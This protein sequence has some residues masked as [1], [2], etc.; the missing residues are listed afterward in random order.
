M[1]HKMLT[2][3]E[4]HPAAIVVNSDAEQGDLALSAGHLVYRGDLRRTSIFNGDDLAPLGAGGTQ[5]SFDGGWGNAVLNNG[6]VAKR[7]VASCAYVSATRTVMI[8]GYQ[9][10]WL[11]VGAMVG[12]AWMGGYIEDYFAVGTV[13]SIDGSAVTFARDVVGSNKTVTVYIPDLASETFPDWTGGAL[14]AAVNSGLATANNAFAANA[15]QAG[16]SAGQGSF[17]AALNLGR[18]SGLRAFAANQGDATAE[19]ATALGTSTAAGTTSL[20]TG[21]ACKTEQPGTFTHGYG[22]LASMYGQQAQGAQVTALGDAQWSRVV[23]SRRVTLSTDAWQ[24]ITG[25]A[26]GFPLVEGGSAFLRLTFVA[27]TRASVADNVNSAEGWA[28]VS[29]RDGVVRID[30]SSLTVRHSTIAS[31]EFGLAANSTDSRIEF[32]IRDTSPAS[33]AVQAIVTAEA[34]ETTW[35]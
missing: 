20:A 33:R 17:S 24:N 4:L 25:G 6:R 19:N 7:V 15:G 23:I 14:M 10:G 16:N 28:V 5:L 1:Q 31:L 32:Q 13:E 27:I 26:S 18:T 29:R 30:A 9:A 2:G 11:E 3:E 35:A 12:L 8:T 34:A 21:M 22:A